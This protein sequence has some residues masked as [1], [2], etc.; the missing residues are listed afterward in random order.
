MAGITDEDLQRVL[1]ND[2][3]GVAALLADLRPMDVLR[4]QE[5]ETQGQG[6][7]PVL[8]AINH[9]IEQQQEAEVEMPGTSAVPRARK[10]K[11]T[12]KQQRGEEIPEHLKPDYSGPLTID[13]MEKRAAYFAAQIK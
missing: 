2:A 13:L 1:E 11:N 10:T 8:D 5:L 7:A 4:L 6:R 12:A 9:Y 3:A